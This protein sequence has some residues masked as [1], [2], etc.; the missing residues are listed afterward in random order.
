MKLGNGSMTDSAKHLRDKNE[1]EQRYLIYVRDRV[2]DPTSLPTLQGKSNFEFQ[3]NRRNAIDAEKRKA[4]NAPTHEDA[5]IYSK[6]KEI[7]ICKQDP[8]F[9]DLNQPEISI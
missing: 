1:E 3:A 6:G 7:Q 4:T 2:A 5:K 9:L 8:R